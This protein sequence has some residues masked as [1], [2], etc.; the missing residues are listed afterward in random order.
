MNI[1]TTIFVLS[2]QIKKLQE[3]YIFFNVLFYTGFQL[4]QTIFFMMLLKQYF[5]KKRNQTI[6]QN[7]PHP[8]KINGIIHKGYIK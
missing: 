8:T 4:E 3:Q 5:Y 6:D 7:K 2:T 1:I